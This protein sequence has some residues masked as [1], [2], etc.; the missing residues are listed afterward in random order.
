MRCY[1]L[2]LVFD[3]F[4]I[5]HIC[6][7]FVSPHCASAIVCVSFFSLYLSTNICWSKVFLWNYCHFKSSWRFIKRIIYELFCT[8]KVYHFEGIFSMWKLFLEWFRCLGSVRTYQVHIHMSAMRLKYGKITKQSVLLLWLWILY[9]RWIST[10]KSVRHLLFVKKINQMCNQV[11]LIEINRNKLTTNMNRIV[12]ETLDLSYSRT[13]KPNNKKLSWMNSKTLLQHISFSIISKKFTPKKRRRKIEKK[14]R[15]KRKV[16]TLF[17]IPTSSWVHA[18][19]AF[20]YLFFLWHPMT[21][22]HS[23]LFSSLHIISNWILLSVERQ[24]KREHILLR[25]KHIVN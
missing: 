7:F 5:F 18:Q 4:H 1:L 2:F 15:R 12:V 25:T 23:P 17:R 3:S 21:T 8:I 16:S 13:S 22:T 19:S 9:C 20:I 24:K 6:F 10:A 11:W 14:I